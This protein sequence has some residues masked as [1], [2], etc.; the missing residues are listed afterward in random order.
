MTKC[1]KRFHNFEIHGLI[2]SC[3]KD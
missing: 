1:K 3:C 2:F